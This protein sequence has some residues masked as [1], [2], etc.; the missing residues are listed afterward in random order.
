M[1]KKYKNGYWD[2]E[3]CA[4]E[5][6]KYKTRTEFFKSSRSAY[7]SAL[8]NCWLNELCS[9]MTIVGSLYHRYNY[10]YEFTDNHVYI[11]LTCDINRRNNEHLTNDKSPVYKHIKKSGLIPKLIVDEL[12]TI[13]YAQTKEITLISNY[14]CNGWFL[15]NKAKGGGLGSNKRKWNETNSVIE[16]LKYKTRTE[17]QK[18]SHSAYK[19]CLKN[20]L[21]D[22]A[23][24][25]MI[26][27]HKIKPSPTNKK[28]TKDIC[29]SEALKFRTKKEFYINSQNAYRF[30][31]RNGFLSEICSHMVKKIH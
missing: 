22:L 7:K 15:L 21:L 19:I 2:K 11:G 3:K 18:L 20:N 31:I 28:W 8:R 9:H 25:H 10:I 23:C 5:A 12:K 16:A 1:V 24:S 30:S 6:L 26:K 29:K 13:D 14:K 17:F 4:K 27:N